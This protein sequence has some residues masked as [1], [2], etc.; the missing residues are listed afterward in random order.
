MQ[1]LANKHSP[2]VENHARIY[3]GEGD[4]QQGARLETRRDDILRHLE[5]TPLG[6]HLLIPCKLVRNYTYGDTISD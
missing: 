4:P 3:A 2:S 5:R 6:T 1:R